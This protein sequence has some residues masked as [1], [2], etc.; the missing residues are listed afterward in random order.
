MQFSTFNAD[1]NEVKEVLDFIEEVRALLESIGDMSMPMFP[2]IVKEAYISDVS[3]ILQSLKMTV[4]DCASCIQNGSFAD[5]FTL[6]RKYRDDSLYGLYLTVVGDKQ[7]QILRET[8]DKSMEELIN[9]YEAYQQQP[10]DKHERNVLDWVKNKQ[11]RVNFKEIVKHVLQSE[12][13][14][15]VNARFNLQ[16]KMEDQDNKL[17]NYVHSNGWK[18]LNFQYVYFKQMQKQCKEFQN[19]LELFTL[20]LLVGLIFLEPTVIMASDWFDYKECG[21]EPPPNSDYWVD[22]RVGD[23]FVKYGATLDEN[24]LAYLKCESG[25]LF[26]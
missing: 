21:M 18:F 20:V 26:D 2:L 24:L 19:C 11:G 22:S 10:P 1:E 6:L 23:F 9:D 16:K 15:A 13:M 4:M 7:W 5:A 3:V 25:M 14:K 8:H 17:N 12:R